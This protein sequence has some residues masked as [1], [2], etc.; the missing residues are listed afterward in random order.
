MRI[1]FL[2]RFAADEKGVTIVEFAMILP[3]LCV[4]LLGI[5]DLGY[6]S[7]AHSVLL[8]AVHDAAR[9]ATV[10]GLTVEEIDER[11]KLRLNHF[12]E[13]A[14]VTTEVDSYFDFTGV[15]TPEKITQDT[16]PIGEYN[17]GDCFEDSNGN[18]SY[19]ID[20]GRTGV[21][22]ADDVVRY[23]V[24]LEFPRIVPIGRFIGWSDQVTMS[25]NTVLR[26][27]PYAG[28]ATTA[29]IICD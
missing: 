20:R 16:H 9:M 29:E 1:R 19:D 21:G 11:V 24:T 14:Q 18:G 5:F 28:R 25:A 10:G 8:G 6:R 4:L 23:R 15:G 3:T 13:Y 17:S 12:G 27:Q 2:S 22:G 26:N 7:Y